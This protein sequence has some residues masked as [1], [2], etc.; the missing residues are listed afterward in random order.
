MGW[1][2]KGARPNSQLF[3]PPPIFIKGFPVRNYNE[4]GIMYYA[5]NCFL[6]AFLDD[7]INNRATVNLSFKPVSF[8][9]IEIDCGVLPTPVMA[10]KVLET[11]TKVDGVVRYACKEKGY[12]I[13][14]SEMR[15]C[16]STGV[17]SGFTTSCKSKCLIPFKY[18]EK[19]I[20]CSCSCLSSEY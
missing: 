15:T 9:P 1:S 5:F 3:Y 7:D 19:D 18:T 16:L 8:P 12:E 4:N 14:G 17:W 20:S 10:T 6:F 2:A 13:I 11:G